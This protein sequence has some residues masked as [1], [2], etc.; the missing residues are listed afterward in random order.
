MK[1]ENDDRDPVEV[2]YDI[3]EKIEASNSGAIANLEPRNQ[4]GN[5]S[6]VMYECLEKIVKDGPIANDGLQSAVS[7]SVTQA[8][9][10]LYKMYAIDREKKGKSYQYEATALGEK[11]IQDGQTTLNDSEEGQD[12]DPE[13]VKERPWDK[14]DVSPNQYHALV[15]LEKTAEKIDRHPTT[16]DMNETFVELANP[17][18]RPDG[19]PEASTYM[20]VLNKKGFVD[21]TPKPHQYWITEKG[22]KVLNDD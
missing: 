14:Y 4:V 5:P 18:R 12:S 19:R 6:T 3:E 21:R 22:K 7:G 13:S 17:S 1:P 10:R 8:V 15:A 20:S 11:L 16:N 2:L 9:S